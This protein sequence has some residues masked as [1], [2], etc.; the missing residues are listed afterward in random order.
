M[1]SFKK[2]F[3]DRRFR[4]G[5]FST[6]MVIAAIV[7]FIL[8]NLV[9]DRL[10]ITR[11][12]TRE[13]IFSLSSGSLE[14]IRDLDADIRI[15]SLWPTGQENF[16]LEQLLAEYASNSN[17]ITVTNRDPI[18]HPH[19][20]EQFAQ[21]DEAI[22]IGSIIVIGPERYRVIPAQELFGTEVIWEGFTPRHVPTSINLE[23]LVTNAINFVRTTETP[24]IYH[25]TGNN[26]FEL[27]PGF[28]AEVEM[29]GF[30]IRQA[31]LL[32]NEVPYDADILLIT[33]PGR[34][35]SEQQALRI[36]QYLQNNGRVILFGSFRG[37]TRF[38]NFDSFLA[39]YGL[40]IGS[41]L[42]VETNPSYIM[43]N[44]PIMMLPDFIP[45][46]ITNPLID[47]NFVPLYF[48]ATG[49][50]I[51]EMRRAQTQIVPLVITSMQAFG[52]V[53]VYEDAFSRVE[54]DIDGPFL[55]AV[56]VE[57][58]F[59]LGNQSTN[60]RMVVISSDSLLREDVNQEIAGTNYSFI[61]NSLN[62]LSG[63]QTRVW[64]PGRNLPT[65]MPLRMTRLNVLAISGISVIAL[66]LTFGITGLVVWLRRRNA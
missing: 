39:A 21:A 47:R 40:K 53:D 10:D 34:D 59:L 65:T 54:S 62:W 26:E 38:P 17:R 8:I 55:L 64:I 2:S 37:D 5:T 36:G 33:M 43:M 46:E 15:Y 35:W 4:Y 31:D 41:Y 50:D 61:I 11:D 57:E 32:T 14:I 23:P 19:F 27:P 12:F 9:A 25:V 52:R 28:V 58:H 3:T 29:A 16:I 48:T 51:L 56:T 49:I 66:P 22:P 24:I 45:N 18:L 44:L 6:A 13:R 63:A 1:T 30:E 42:I 20:V 60:A 7:L